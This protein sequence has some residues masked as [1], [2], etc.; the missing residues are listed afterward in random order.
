MY[1]MTHG[2][3]FFWVPL[4]IATVISFS[5]KPCSLFTRMIFCLTALFLEPLDFFYSDFTAFTNHS[6]WF[7]EYSL[8]IMTQTL[9]LKPKLSRFILWIW[10][11]DDLVSSH[12]AGFLK[13]TKKQTFHNPWFRFKLGGN[14]CCLCSGTESCVC[15]GKKKSQHEQWQC[16]RLTGGNQ[17]RQGSRV[18]IH[19]FSTNAFL[20]RP[21]FCFNFSVRPGRNNSAPSKRPYSFLNLS[22][23]V[24]NV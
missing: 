24:C 2:E 11:W 6:K 7:D 13:T 21:S 3:H 20:M 18:W 12:Q 17:P 22:N 16:Q 9:S 5:S 1:S 15:A 19:C 8:T 10:S 23:D 4:M 14:E